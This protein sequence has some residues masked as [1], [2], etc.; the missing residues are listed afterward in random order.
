MKDLISLWRSKLSNLPFSLF[1]TTHSNHTCHLSSPFLIPFILHI[2]QLLGLT[3]I[4][5]ILCNKEG[6]VGS[7]GILQPW[8]LLRV[9]WDLDRP[10]LVLGTAALQ[11]GAWR[12]QPSEV[13]STH[14]LTQTETKRET[15]ERQKPQTHGGFPKY[16]LQI[17]SSTI[18]SATLQSLFRIHFSL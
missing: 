9:T 5:Q 7:G 17:D 11:V 4:M 10:D 8:K 15:E 18:F 2:T 14:E 12:R 13:P 6:K 1:F 3:F 16:V